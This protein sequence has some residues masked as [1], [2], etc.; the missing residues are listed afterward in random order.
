M[1][2]NTI[3][4]YRFT[5]MDD[6]KVIDRGTIAEM[7]DEVSCYLRSLSSKYKDV[8]RIIVKAHIEVMS[9]DEND[10]EINDVEVNE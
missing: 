3:I 9:V 5:K 4:A 1:K 7:A 6:G 2:D 10:V 8:H